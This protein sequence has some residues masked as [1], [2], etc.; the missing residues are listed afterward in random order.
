[1]SESIVLDLIL[2]RRKLGPNKLL[3]GMLLLIL[4]ES[5]LVC[6]PGLTPQV[7][8]WRV[9]DLSHTF[10]LIVLL[11]PVYLR[12]IGVPLKMLICCSLD[13]RLLLKSLDVL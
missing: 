4:L 8:R 5:S 2:R 6:I 3:L 10:W 7:L 11:C 12:R 13:L 9:T 1:L